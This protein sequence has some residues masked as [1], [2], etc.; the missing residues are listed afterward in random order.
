MYYCSDTENSEVEKRG[1]VNR[2]GLPEYMIIPLNKDLYDML[3][4]NCCQQLKA[5][6]VDDNRNNVKA[7]IKPPRKKLQIEVNKHISTGNLSSDT[8]NANRHNK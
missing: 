2:H 1:N 7:P 3:L 4:G 5:E 6:E 8:S